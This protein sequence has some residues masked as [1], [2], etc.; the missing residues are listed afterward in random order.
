M[1]TF[2]ELAEPSS[3]PAWQDEFLHPKKYR[4]HCSQCGRMVPFATV[5]KRS[6]S[7]PDWYDEHIYDGVCRVHGPV[8]VNWPEV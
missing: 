6:P 8:E 1:S 7:G 3:G 4:W 2:F 5:K